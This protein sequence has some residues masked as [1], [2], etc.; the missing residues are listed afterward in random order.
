MVVNDG[1][2][3]KL[4]VEQPLVQNSGPDPFEVSDADTMLSYLK[5]AKKDEL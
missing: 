3:E 4:F 1:V 5:N 2:I